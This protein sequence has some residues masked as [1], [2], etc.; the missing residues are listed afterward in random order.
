MAF[1]HRT[2]HATHRE[3]N[4]PWQ[5][6]ICITLKGFGD[7]MV[8]GRG[9]DTLFMRKAVE[10]CGCKVVGFSPEML[11]R[12]LEIT[13]ILLFY[14]KRLIYGKS[15]ESNRRFGSPRPLSQKERIR[16]FANTVRERQYSPPE[17]S[18]LFLLLIVGLLFYE[19]GRRRAD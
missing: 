9:A 3:K 19:Y 4:R 7:F 17:A 10:Q 16:V 14:K 15:N 1:Q 11:V 6:G 12:H 8:L 2:F 5:T 13:Q 18:L